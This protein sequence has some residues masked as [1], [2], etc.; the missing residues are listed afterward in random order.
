MG[1]ISRQA[2]IGWYEPGPVRGAKYPLCQLLYPSLYDAW[3]GRTSAKQEEK[4]GITEKYAT[5]PVGII[6]PCD[7]AKEV[8][9][10]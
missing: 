6:F 2:D 9:R 1:F 8:N 3:T 4:G 5:D 7:Q 10:R